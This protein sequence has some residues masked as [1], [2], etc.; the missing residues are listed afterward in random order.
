[1]TTSFLLLALPV[2]ALIAGPLMAGTRP[3]VRNGA[4][5]E[6]YQ[7]PIRGLPTQ[8]VP[9]YNTPGSG[10][11]TRSC[12]LDRLHSACRLDI[13]NVGD[14]RN[15]KPS[16]W[17]SGLNRSTDLRRRFQRIAMLYGRIVRMDFVVS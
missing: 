1:V 8:I 11:Q 10:E 13:S 4:H 14:A 12:H 2:A 7:P 5:P 3:V 6:F 9:Q 17:A 15:Y 16:A